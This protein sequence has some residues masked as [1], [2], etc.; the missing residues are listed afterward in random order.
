[1]HRAIQQEEYV[2]SAYMRRAIQQEEE[3]NN[4]APEGQKFISTQHVSA[5][6]REIRLVALSIA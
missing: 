1:M 6:V 4:F 2:G 5:L 3:R